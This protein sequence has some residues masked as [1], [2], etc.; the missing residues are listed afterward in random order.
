MYVK[1]VIISDSFRILINRTCNILLNPQREQKL[2]ATFVLDAISQG[3]I[4]PIVDKEFRLED[5]SEP[6]REVT[7]LVTPKGKYVLVF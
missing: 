2:A 6:H 5:V 3:N 7:N 4:T 1:I